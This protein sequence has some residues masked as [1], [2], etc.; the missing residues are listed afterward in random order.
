M[1]IRLRLPQ[2]LRGLCRDTRGTAAM[3]FAVVLPIMFTLLFGIYEVVQVV[4]ANMQLANTATSIADMVA[5]QSAGV[6]SGPA[7]SLGNFCKAAR[8]MMA[9]FPAEATS[10]PGTFSVAIASLTHY[11]AGGVTIDWESDGSCKASATRLGASA[12]S[13]ATSPTNLLPNA[14]SPGDSIIVVQASYR[15]LSAI[16]YVLPLP[17]VLKQTAFARPRGDQPITCT[18]PCS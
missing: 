7:G 8:M 13:L 15:Y 12:T 5:Q 18:A 9:P 3:E 4:R 11:T 6:T 17:L 1:P 2:R 14:G 16:Q 10:G